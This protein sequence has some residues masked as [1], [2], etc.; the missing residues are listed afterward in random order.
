[1]IT[2]NVAQGS[3][4]WM[5]ARV[6]IPSASKFGE[7]VTTKGSPSKQQQKYMYTL[8]GE[9]VIGKKEETYQN[10]AM[11]RGIEMEAEA[12]ALY[13]MLNDV[14]VEQVGLCYPDEKKLYACSPD[15]LVDADG[16]L[17]IKCPL[18]S[19]IVGYHVKGGLVEAY[20]QQLQG[21]LLVTDRRWVD[22]MAYYPAFKPLIIRVGR[23]ETFLDALEAQL[24]VFRTELDEITNTLKKGD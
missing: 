4:E 24:E 14:K 22:I 12:R 20:W 2:L 11:T 19:T 18:L 21:Q 6:G 10:A 3:D 15:G 23:H 7:I 1:M 17:E 8:A 9:R 5:Q 16:M 13:E